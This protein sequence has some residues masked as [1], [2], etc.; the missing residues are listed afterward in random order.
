MGKKG[1]PVTI[2]KNDFIQHKSLPFAKFKL[3]DYFKPLCKIIPD[4]SKKGY[5][6]EIIDQPGFLQKG[7]VCVYVIDG[8]IL[9]I[10]SSLTNFKDRISAS[11]YYA[12]ECVLAIGLVATVFAYFPQLPR[13]QVFDKE[14]SDFYS[15]S[16]TGE[17][18]ALEQLL[19][20]EKTRP[21]A[22]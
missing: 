18:E 17:E 20:Q 11:G 22:N 15:P 21:L 16:R 7:L 3:R 13:Y 8:K 1:A 2:T 10:E 6:L 9:R 14:Y 12:L 4:L 5:S 19:T